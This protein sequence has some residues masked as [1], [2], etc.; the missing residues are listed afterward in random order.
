M[1]IVTETVPRLTGHR[2]MTLPEFL[3]RYPESYAH[4]MPRQGRVL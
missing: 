1:D 4:L 2:A 3:D